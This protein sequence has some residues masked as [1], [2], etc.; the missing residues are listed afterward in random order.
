MPRYFF[1]VRDSGEFTDDDGTELAGLAEVRVQAVIAAG[2]AIK[3]LGE[4]FWRT[5]EW[6]MRVTNEAGETVCQLSF[7]EG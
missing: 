7:R 1:H 2:E 3:D 6:H 5:E 4:R